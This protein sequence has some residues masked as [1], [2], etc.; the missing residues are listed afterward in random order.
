[1]DQ[2]RIDNLE[3]YAHHGVYPEENRK[4]QKFYVNAV[5]YTDTRKAGQQDDLELST[6]YGEVCLFIQDYMTERVCKLLETVAEGLAEAILL[7]FPKIRKLDL[8]I[9]KPN[10]PIPLPFTSVSI[11]ITRGWHKVFIAFGS[12]MGDRDTYIANAL[13]SIAEHPLCRTEKVSSVLRTT[14]Y[15]G[16]A[17]GEFLNGVLQIR[18]LFT[19]EE[20]LEV[21]H[22]LEAEAGRQRTVHWGSRTL[23]LDI[24]FFDDLVMSTEIL[25]IPHVDM[26]NR[27][28]VLRP[29]CEIAPYFRHPVT[30]QTMQ[31]MLE[32][33]TEHHVL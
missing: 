8:E 20:L 19:P 17:E 25:T 16:Q 5:L 10:A 7:Q 22:E 28:F 18:T 4:G 6:N 15:G 29:L 1:M 27:D 32:N 23:D 2:I 21:L 33:L 13:Q 24:L 12:N 26:Q 31:Q 11:K 30:N 3:V 9:R 14:P